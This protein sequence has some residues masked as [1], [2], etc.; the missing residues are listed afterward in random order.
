MYDYLIVGCGLY[1]ATIG[2]LLTNKGYSVY[3]IDKRNHIAGNIYTERKDNIDIHV[4]G[5]HV[6]HTN[7]EDVWKFVNKYAKF[8]NYELNTLAFD[9]D[10]LYHLPFNMNTFH[11]IFNIEYP[12]EAKEII[13]NE[14]KNSGLL[15]KNPYNLEEQ[16]I[17]IVGETIYKKLIK[18][19]TEKQ[20]NKKCNELSPDIIK[21]L[22]LR[23]NY[24]NNYFDDKY[25]GI[26]TNGYTDMNKSILTGI[27]NE[28][29]IKY[30]LNIDFIKN[31]G[32][33]LSQAKNVIYCGEIDRLFN[34]SLGELEW[35]S[36]KF[37]HY[38]FNDKKF[39]QG[40]AIKNMTMSKDICPATRYIE[41]YYFNPINE[42]NSIYL[43]E[44]I[45]QNWNRNLDPYYPINNK[46][47]E[48]LYNDY[49]KL[50]KNTYP[51]IKLG[52]RLGKYKYFDM[53]DTIIEAFKD[54]K[55]LNNN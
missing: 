55:I 34:Y 1:G 23:F 11:K 22:P 15:N 4:Y 54:I 13:N 16:A 46:R 26:P 38:K 21:R 45:P 3:I 27:G 8:N 47:N 29:K 19:Y 49:I 42:Y 20:W 53:D 41:H 7:N 9:G 39:S 37:N 18:Y 14:I 40:V 52:G 51:K 30:A 36:L 12:Y 33:W 48:K 10:D 6:F 25:Q 43:S 2:R 31:I 24:N 35:R 44:E 32:Y 50:L 28:S 5:P 17:K